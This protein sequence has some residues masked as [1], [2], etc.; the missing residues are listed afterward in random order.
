[1][2]PPALLMVRMIEAAMVSFDRQALDP[3]D[4]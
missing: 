3:V 4:Q 2:G 1:M